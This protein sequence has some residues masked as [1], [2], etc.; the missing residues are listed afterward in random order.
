M[1]NED[2]VAEMLD[3]LAGALLL[4]RAGDLLRLGGSLSAMR[5]KAN[6]STSAPLRQRALGAGRTP[7]APPKLHRS[8]EPHWYASPGDA[9]DLSDMR[10]RCMRS[11]QPPNMVSI[12]TD[13][14]A[15]AKKTA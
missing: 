5:L 10:G 4:E 7:Q 2:G 6:A 13:L 15:N 12:Q 3:P 14:H 9:V 11:R 1:A 8:G